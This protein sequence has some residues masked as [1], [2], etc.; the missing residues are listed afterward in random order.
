MLDYIAESIRKQFSSNYSQ[1]VGFFFV[2]ISQNTFFKDLLADTNYSFRYFKLLIMQP[3]IKD[4][5]LNLYRTV[6]Q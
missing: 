3:F 1:D 2:K 4:H 6:T 5:H